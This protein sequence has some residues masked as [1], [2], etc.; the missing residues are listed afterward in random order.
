LRG[1]IE[2]PNRHQFSDTY[3]ITSVDSCAI[4][5]S[6]ASSSYDRY[7]DGFQSTSTSI[8]D[9]RN[10]NPAVVL[11]ITDYGAGW[12][13]ASRSVLTASVVKGGSP[14]VTDKVIDRIPGTRDTERSQADKFEIE[15]ADADVAE[16]IGKVFG[17]EIAA[18]H[19]AQHR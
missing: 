19:A 3:R 6:H 16:V 5:V 12:K 1:S 11:R 7:Y 14:I 4:T 10:L 18:C 8:V 13:P 9:L 17:E 15:F 2:R